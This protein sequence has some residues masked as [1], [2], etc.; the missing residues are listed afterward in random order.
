MARTYP[1]NVRVTTGQ[2]NIPENVTKNIIMIDPMETP[3][4]SSMRRRKTR[5]KV[6]ECFNDSLNAPKEN[7]VAEGADAEFIAEGVVIREKA[8]TQLMDKAYTVSDAAQISSHYGY[9]SQAAYIRGKRAKELKR[10]MEKAL[11]TN[12]SSVKPV[13]G[14][15]SAAGTGAVA[16]QTASISAWIKTN[17][18]SRYTNAVFSDKG[19][20]D[21]TTELTEKY[22]LNP[23]NPAD[24]DKTQ[25]SEAAVKHMVGELIKHTDMVHVQ[26]IYLGLGNKQRASQVL[27]GIAPFRQNNPP[28]RNALRAVATVSVYV[29]DFGTH[30]ILYNRWM[31][32]DW[33]MYL[34]PRY[35]RL[36]FFEQ[37][38][39]KRLARTG[40]ARKEML[41][42]EFGLECLNEKTS[43]LQVGF[44]DGRY[45]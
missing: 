33:A 31:P 6:F 22:V 17:L 21:S 25:F 26:Q 24:G 39:R 35:W 37:F 36:R 44:T 1:V 10:D 18:F 32:D 23:A 12:R 41:S 4:L 20:Y 2:T 16:S 9:A 34:D 40:H 43:G 19:G 7:A 42:V 15:G 8:R 3:C 28:S 30:R 13:A 11:V 38:N 27:M 29:S 14:D 5:T 45:A